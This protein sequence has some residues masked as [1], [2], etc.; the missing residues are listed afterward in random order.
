MNGGILHSV[1]LASGRVCA[2][3][4][5]SRLVSYLNSLQSTLEVSQREASVLQTYKE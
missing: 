3:S 1:G 2:C 4:V 5:R